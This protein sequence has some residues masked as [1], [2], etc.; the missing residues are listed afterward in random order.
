M[1]AVW[2]EFCPV[3]KTRFS[4]CEVLVYILTL[5]AAALSLLLADQ[6]LGFATCL[7]A[8]FKMNAAWYLW[9]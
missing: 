5:I 2:F 3:A 4:N 8:A 9:E 6:N 7:T 1:A